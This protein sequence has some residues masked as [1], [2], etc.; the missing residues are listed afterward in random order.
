MKHRAHQ[1]KHRAESRRLTFVED[2]FLD[3]LE[4]WIIY[5]VTLLSST[6]LVMYMLYMNGFI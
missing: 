3:I 5:G 2:I 1:R 4:N 6:L